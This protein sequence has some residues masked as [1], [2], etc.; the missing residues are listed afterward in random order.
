[1]YLGV[2]ETLIVDELQQLID[3]D[4][5]DRFCGGGLGVQSMKDTSSN[6]LYGYLF[7]KILRWVAVVVINDDILVSTMQMKMIERGV[8]ELKMIPRSRSSLLR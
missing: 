4:V 3:G 1:M 7:L 6:P 2:I 8:N 5:T